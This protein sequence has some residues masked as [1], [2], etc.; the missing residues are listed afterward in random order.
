MTIYLID[1][2]MIAILIYTLVWL[3][4]FQKQREK[5][6]AE[7]QKHLDK[8]KEEIEKMKKEYEGRNK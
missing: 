3:I 8:W 5:D 1:A 4:R 2:V 6:Y 7:W